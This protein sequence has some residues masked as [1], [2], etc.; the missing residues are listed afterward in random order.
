MCAPFVMMALVCAGTLNCKQQSISGRDIAG[1]LLGNAAALSS[2]A[3]HAQLR[4]MRM[5]TCGF[6]GKV[7]VQ[8]LVQLRMYGCCASASADTWPADH[9][10][11]VTL[12]LGAVLHKSY[13][14]LAMSS[15]QQYALYGIEHRNA[16]YVCFCCHSLLQLLCC[17]AHLLCCKL[18]HSCERRLFRYTEPA[19]Q[20]P[21]H[22]L[23]Q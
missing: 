7:T 4:S 14:Q 16:M 3:Q 13:H 9:L 11:A 8:L 17:S 20:K 2:L 6:V 12:L 23:K 10:Q 5:R 21:T 19:N 15:L 22:K 18:Q 1:N